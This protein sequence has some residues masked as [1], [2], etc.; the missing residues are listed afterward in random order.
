MPT[1]QINGIHINLLGD[2]NPAI[3]HPA[4][5]AS[6]KLITEAEANEATKAGVRFICS[7][8][9]T[10][11][12]IPW[13]TFDVAQD[14][15]NAVTTRE[16]QY[17]ALRDLVLGTFKLLRHSPIKRLGINVECHY[18]YE[19]LDAWNTFGHKL[20]PKEIW[21]KVMDDPGLLALTIIDKARRKHP[22][23]NTRVD[24]QSSTRVQ[25]GIFFGVNNHYECPTTA[26]AGATEAV[27]IIE[28]EFN[29]ALEHSNHIINTLLSL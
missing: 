13:A 29:K 18:K 26:P 10:T 20:V 11:F 14:H 8:Q 3:F 6:E 19:T 17:E 2:L 21:R 7:P 25:P 23:G 16:S 4:W 1:L 22:D 15:F 12:Q 28:S 5:F 9:Y 27:K 24:I